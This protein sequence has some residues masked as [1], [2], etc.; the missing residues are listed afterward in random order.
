[1]LLG[2]QK[3]IKY[4]KLISQ[5]IVDQIS[6]HVT[7]SILSWD[8]KWLTGE[9]R[10]LTWFES[11][12][13]IDGLNQMDMKTSAGFPFIKYA[14]STSKIPWVN[15]HE[16]ENS[17]KTFTPNLDLLQACEQREALAKKG[18]IMPTFFIDTLKD[19]TREL[20]KVE[21]FK[22]R[23]FQVGPFDLSV[24]I[25]KYFGLFMAHC[26]N[27]FIRGEMAI[28]LNP[29]S[30]EWTEMFKH[31]CEVGFNFMCGDVKNFDASLVLQFAMIV[32]DAANRFYSDGPE[33]ALIRRTLIVT[34]FSSTH[35]VDIL[36]YC[37]KLGNVSGNALTTI[38][39]CIINMCF[40]RYVYLKRVENNLLMFDYNVRLKVMGDDNM[41]NVRDT[42]AKKIQYV[43]SER[44]ISADRCRVYFGF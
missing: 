41:C 16:H 21:A 1:M 40:A 33:N 23:V 44:R 9:K 3:N 22:T 19:E 31:F 26:H 11:L 29:L 14:G 32:A 15:V 6:E 34:I 37:M 17:Y 24:V 30:L 4:P 35:I 25:R 12:N 10:L 43:V 20:A 39:N 5:N 18:E 13:G 27:T 38:I 28:G 7:N 42:I 2:L 36:I 8:S